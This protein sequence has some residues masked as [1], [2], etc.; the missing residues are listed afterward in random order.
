MK[1]NLLFLVV[2]LFSSVAFAQTSCD[3]ATIYSNTTSNAVCFDTIGTNVLGCYSNDYPDHDD[4]YN[5]PFTVA[6]SNQEYYMCLY[7]DT[8]VNFT[9]LYEATETA[10]G[11]NYTYQFGVAINGIGLTPNSN[12]TFVDTLT[13]E[14]NIEWHKEARY[15]FNAN[16]GNNGGHINAFGSYHYHDVPVDY[17]TDSLGIS[18][19]GHS[20]IVGYAAD[21]FPIYYKYVYSDPNNSGSGIVGLSSG[22]SLKSGTRTGDGES[23]PDGA[24]SGLYYEDYEYTATDLDSCNGRYG[25][26]PEYPNGTY[27]YVLTDNYPYIPRCFKGTVLDN[28]FRSLSNCPTS[29][30]STDCSEP[31][32]GCM[33]PFSCNYNSSATVDDGSCDYSY[34]YETSSEN[35]STSVVS[36]SGN[37]TWTTSGTYNDTIVAAGCDTVYTVTVTITT[38][39]S[40]PGCSL[41]P[42]ITDWELNTTNK[43]AS[44]W[45]Y[46][47]PGY[48]FNT[49]TDL[50]DV[51][52]VCYDEDT[53]WIES[54][55]MTND[56]G[57]F[58][59]P[60]SV[61]AQGY[62]FKFARDPVA[63]SGT[64]S[65]PESNTIGV[66]LNGIPIYGLGDGK[67]YHFGLGSNEPNGDGLWVG[68][69]YY[70]EGVTLDTAFAAHPQQSGAYHSHATP[71]RY[72]DDPDVVH[73]PLVGFANDGFPVYGPFG[74]ST[75]LDSSSGVARMVSGYALR[76]ITTR[77]TLPDGSASMPPG[78]AVTSGGSY[79]IGSYVQDYEYLGTGTLDE[80]NG[81][82]C[83][84]PEY[85]NGTY[86]YFVT[87]DALGTPQ[88]P[89]Y[90][91]TTYYGTLV[92]DNNDGSVTA[93]SG[94]VCYDGT[95]C[96][97]P[98]ASFTSLNDSVCVDSTMSFT[99]T[100]TESPTSWLWTFTGGT[101]ASSTAQN[102][103]GITYATAGDYDVQLIATNASGTDTI[104]SVAHITAYTCST[105]PVAAFTSSV[106]QSCAGFVDYTD[107]S[108]GNPTSWEWTFSPGG[109]FGVPGTD[110][111]QNPI[112]IS[113]F[114][115][116]SWDV[117]LKVTNEFGSDSIT[118]SNYIEILTCGDNTW[119]GNTDTDWGTASNWLGG[120]VPSAGDT[121][122][123]PSG[124]TNYPVLDMGRT[125]G[126]LE[127]YGGTFDL[128]GFEVTVEGDWDN[129]NGTLVSNSG[130]TKFAGTS[131]QE[132]TGDQTFH[133]VEVDN[134]AGVNITS[135]ADSI[136]GVMTLTSGTFTT[137]NS[138]TIVS[139]ASGTGSIA[140]IQ[141]G[142][143]ITGN[144]E[145]QRYINTGQTNWHLFSSPISG[146]VLSD[147]NDDFETSGIP[148]SLY[149]LF[150]YTGTP[151]A[152]VYEY[153][154][155]VLDHLDSGFVAPSN[156][157]NVMGSGSGYMVWCGDTITGT[158]PFTIDM[159]GPINKGDI[160]MPVTYSN[161]GDSARDGWNLVGNPY[162]S[163]IDWDDT[164]WVK[165]GISDAVYVYDPDLQQ[166]AEYVSG[167]SNNGGSQYI[168]S[169]QGFWVQTVSAT[170]V[171]TA[172]EGVKSNMDSTFFKQGN[173]PFRI[174][175]LKG[176]YKDQTTL[177]I[178]SG[179]TM[180]FD[181]Q[182]DAYK[183]YSTSANV[184]SICTI[185]KDD[186]E[187]SINSINSNSGGSI[188]V[189]IT[190]ATS[191]LAQ[192]TFENL[193]GLSDFNCVYLEDKQSGTF[194]DVLTSSGYTFYL[195]DTTSTARFVLHLEQLVADF[196][197][198][199]TVDL[200]VNNGAFSPSNTSINVSQY[201]WDF[202]DNT[203]ST[204]E[205]PVHHYTQAG[206]YNV[207]L[208][209]GGLQ[210]CVESQVRQ[211]EVVS[212]GVTSVNEL[213]LN[214]LTVYPNPV[215]IGE[216]LQFSFEA[217]SDYTI[218]IVDV[219]GK[220]VLEDR[221]NKKNQ[222]VLVDSNFDTGIYFVRLYD[223]ANTQVKTIKLIVSE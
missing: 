103:T 214:G 46:V 202:G 132:I 30:A 201:F 69:A 169:S 134:S 17:F 164:D 3:T 68:E 87:V 193:S 140:T 213:S 37:Y 22:Y 31:V 55:G 59:N 146:S 158:D 62:R 131:V 80:H 32:F 196:T 177:R 125:I 122:T 115:A 116:G 129:Q 51:L 113:Y 98:V 14:N 77:D 179:A 145:V 44:Y 24:Y 97:L 86:A 117:K 160:S 15:M 56:M 207:R 180:N 197:A 121:I 144:V 18:S 47:G 182:Y 58:S 138:L 184:P 126:G 168:A 70:T 25:I 63:G 150:P 195:Y 13:G 128:N 50:A 123:I 157:S 43:T 94:V 133:D 198:V 60:G 100:S 139:D 12:E 1:K 186:G 220:V 36:P 188:P 173:L 2:T 73:S 66:L 194:I 209:V 39:S 114:V 143:D 199:D 49:T 6:A 189:K 78:P 190:A 93:P 216:H 92:A 137:N 21:G 175:V 33:D 106:T 45:E 8:A 67:S 149:P 222:S 112:G 42:V 82:L 187:L 130:S 76:N 5:S 65:V 163:T 178:G 176:S 172:K 52:S 185:S 120:I 57:Q 192:L 11:C 101:P 95:T 84:T 105:P 153:D 4:S 16:F 85:P 48:S 34:T 166:F 217:T 206:L 154:E 136:S 53:V 191:G 40:T 79:D 204:A 212:S 221:V 102:P 20:S 29:T 96:P 156:M 118:I 223:A 148:G 141:S 10:L 72:Y 124:R 99:D 151:W 71:F 64:E 159:A 74:Y 170:P 88:F 135:G 38:N 215:K 109:S 7:P 162:P 205:N 41:Q 200:G 35:S 91:G 181:S 75:A 152:S 61:I 127:F 104:T 171:L 54:E 28:T 210:S 142:A 9:P 165:T 83:V 111:L 203:T 155:T 23:A 89:Y 183:M 208:E 174:N 110:T 161:S 211:V 119:Q 27:Y 167:A 147:W 81:R 108:T 219:L 19:S 218:S 107:L 26:T 90:V